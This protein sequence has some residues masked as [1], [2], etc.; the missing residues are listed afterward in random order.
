M[1]LVSRSRALHDSG[2]RT[3]GNDERLQLALLRRALQDLRLDRV[4]AQQAKDQHRPRLPYPVRTVLR[5]EVC[6]RVL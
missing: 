6:L 1:A 3:F 2:P 5:L 4:C